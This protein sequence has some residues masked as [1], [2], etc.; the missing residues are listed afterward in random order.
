[1][2]KLIIIGIKTIAYDN[3][4]FNNFVIGKNDYLKYFVFCTLTS[5]L[6][7]YKYPNKIK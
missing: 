3:I 4:L 2:I 5:F 1:M 7:K 6:L